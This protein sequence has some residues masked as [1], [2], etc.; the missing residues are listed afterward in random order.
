[1][2]IAAAANVRHFQDFT[3]K[4]SKIYK[5][6]EEKQNRLNIF[7]NNYKEMEEHNEKFKQGLV[8]WDM[9]VTANKP[10]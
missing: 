7:M 3:T 8:S 9:K 10:F 6:E 2:A 5:T 4:F 1:M